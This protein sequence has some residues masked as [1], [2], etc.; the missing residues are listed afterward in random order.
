MFGNITCAVLWNSVIPKAFCIFALFGTFAFEAQECCLGGSQGFILIIALKNH[1]S[2]VFIDA[3]LKVS[4]LFVGW[5]FCSIMSWAVL[6]DDSFFFSYWIMWAYMTHKIYCF[7]VLNSQVS[8]VHFLRQP[9]IHIRKPDKIACEMERKHLLKLEVAE[10]T[11]THFQL[12]STSIY[13]LE[14]L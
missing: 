1:S 13:H 3:V 12:M 7:Q 10:R 14:G 8:Q 9:C 2:A 4:D 11:I 6:L 5:I